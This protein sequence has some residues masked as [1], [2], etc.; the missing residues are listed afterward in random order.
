MQNGILLV[1]LI[2]FITNRYNKNAVQ[3]LAKL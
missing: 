1:K 3:N 2:Q